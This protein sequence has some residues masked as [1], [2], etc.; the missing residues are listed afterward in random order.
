MS[1]TLFLPTRDLVIF[2][3]IVTPIYVGRAKSV[4]TLESA[5][6]SKSKLVLGMQK[7]P[8]KEDPE[9]PNDIYKIGVIVNILQIVKMPNN[10]IKVL[11]EAED[12]VMIED[13]ETTDT[14]YTATYKTIKCT[15]GKA[16]E[17]EAIYI[18]DSF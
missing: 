1:K 12:R 7:D 10:N 16:K 17:T 15:N 4:S 3:G 8:S 14:E 11:I 13:V 18:F 2:P 5:V 9:L 6:N